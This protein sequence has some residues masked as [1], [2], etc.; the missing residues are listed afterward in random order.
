M[1]ADTWYYCD[2]EVDDERAFGPFTLEQ[3]AE[4]IRTGK[5]SF[6]FIVSREGTEGSKWVHADEVEEILDAVPLDV[7]RLMTEYIGYGE[8]PPGDE[9]WGWASDRMYQL[10]DYFPERAWPLIIEMIDRAPSEDC[11]SF[12]A[13]SPL[14]NLLSK[15]GPAFIDRVEQR[16]AVN[17]KFRRA[18]GMLKRLGMTDDVWRRVQAAKPG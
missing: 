10:L 18:L 15:D 2:W 8:T 11:L 9:K 5:V 1:V 4:L 13:A 14:E 7:E 3:L 17:A 16:A 12:L 6:D